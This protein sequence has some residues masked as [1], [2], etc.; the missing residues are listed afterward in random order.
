MKRSS[1]WILISAFIIGFWII[2][3]SMLLNWWQEKQAVRAI[4]GEAAN[5]GYVGMI[6]VAEVIRHRGGV[7]GLMAKDLAR[8]DKEPAWVW[9]QA[10][11]AWKASKMTNYTRGADHFENVEAFGK[12]DWA[13]QM[14][15]TAIINDHV[16]YKE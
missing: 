8:V 12:P 2:V 4:V 5:Q 6:G 3:G 16:F 9:R 7:D 13:K 1:V 11:E 15:V 10:V 14:K